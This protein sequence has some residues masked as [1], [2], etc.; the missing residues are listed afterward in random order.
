M[1]MSYRFE[2]CFFLKI[3][4]IVSKTKSRC[5]CS[6][7]TFVKLKIAIKNLILKVERNIEGLDLSFVSHMKSKTIYKILGKKYKIKSWIIK[8]NIKMYE[9]FKYNIRN[10]WH[11]IWDILMKK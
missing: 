7:L 5:I 10:I 1:S 11:K 8:N 9:N 6:N 3:V 4:N 2:L